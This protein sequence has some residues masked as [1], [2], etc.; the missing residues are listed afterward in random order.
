MSEIGKEG[1]LLASLI[2]LFSRPAV[3]MWGVEYFHKAY[4]PQLPV[5]GY[6]ECMLLLMTVG[7]FRSCY[8]YTEKWK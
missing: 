6:W 4:F 7:C 8:V 2:H 1:Q 5:F 3:F